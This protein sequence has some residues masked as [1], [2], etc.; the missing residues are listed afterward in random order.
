MRGPGE[1]TPPGL[2]WG[3]RA[4][5][6]SRRGEPEKSHGGGWGGSGSLGSPRC[7]QRGSA[8]LEGPQLS[9]VP[10]FKPGQLEYLRPVGRAQH[11]SGAGA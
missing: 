2:A 7:V 10:K 1:A 4:P 9:E 3:R 6:G 5:W 11:E 8:L